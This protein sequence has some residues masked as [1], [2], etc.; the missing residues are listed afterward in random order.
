MADDLHT[1]APF[2]SVEG[3]SFPRFPNTGAWLLSPESFR[4]SCMCLLDAASRLLIIH[5]VCCGNTNW[6]VFS[7]TFCVERIRERLSQHDK[8]YVIWNRITCRL[9]KCHIEYKNRHFRP[10]SHFYSVWKNTTVCSSNRQ[11]QYPM[12]SF[13]KG[14]ETRHL[15]I[16]NHVSFETELP[17]NCRK[18]D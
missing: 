8:S 3:R 14:F 16:T 18:V 12:E 5:V 4:Q 15:N 9:Q 6:T 17:V 11:S 10:P 13:V 1:L 7:E 2:F